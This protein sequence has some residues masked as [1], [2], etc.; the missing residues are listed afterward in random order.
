MV[1]GDGKET[2]HMSALAVDPTGGENKQGNITKQST[3]IT[4]HDDGRYVTDYGYGYYTKGEDED[5]WLSLTNIG[6]AEYQCTGT[7]Y[8]RKPG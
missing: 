5:I 2:Y 8:L 6:Y 7:T 4:D 1:D 3:L